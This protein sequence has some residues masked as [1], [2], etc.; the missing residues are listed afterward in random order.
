MAPERGTWGTRAGFIL[1]AAGSAVGL[2][3]IWGFPTQVGQGGG[4]AFVLIY[5]ICVVVICAPI[6][7]SEIAI[8][9]RAQ[10]AP[11]GSFRAI[12]PGSSWWLVGLLGVLAGAGILSFYCV[13]AGWTVAYIWFTLTEQ[14]TGSQAE[15]GAFFAEFTANGTAT[16]AL[17]FLVLGVTAG[18]AV[19]G[20]RAG[21]ERVTKALMPA[22]IALLLLLAARASTLP[23]ATEGLTYY[24]KPD[25]SRLLDASLYRAALGQAF[26]SLSLG[27]GAMLTYG[28]YLSKRQGI[29]GS[30]A[31]VVLLDTAIAL[32][33][34]FII[35]PAGFSIEGFDPTS[36]GPGLIFTVLPRLFGA[37][38]GGQLFGAAFFLLLTMAALTSTISLLEVPVAHCVD[39]WGWS[40]RTAVLSVT[41]VVFAFAV[42][43]AL[44][45]GA[46]SIFTSLPALGVD[47][48]TLMS[49]TWNTFALPIG[50]LFTA[51]FVG[52]IWRIDPALEE[53]RAHGAWFPA[54]SV[55][56]FLVR[57]I[58]PLGILSIIISSIYAMF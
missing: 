41:G 3:N 37:L 12:R 14:V 29:A 9:R 55:W 17:A 30:A 58:C 15:I 5:L 26:F 2:G 50:G 45:A 39:S 54:A 16:V 20:V 53:L 7:I 32:L 28:S 13:I 49:T 8:G 31:W 43:S 48:L 27:M 21:I 57:W 23:G 46:T 4:A 44:S 51:L 40:R 19:G 36:S 35:F 52:W 34:G 18:V 11:V 42:P 10:Q 22:L 33:A 38:P 6:L 1:A 47:F 24:L 25:F 56:S